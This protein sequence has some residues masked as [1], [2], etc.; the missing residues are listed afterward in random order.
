MVVN[1]RRSMSDDDDGLPRSEG[2]KAGDKCTF[3]LTVER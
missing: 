2:F 3:G 1:H